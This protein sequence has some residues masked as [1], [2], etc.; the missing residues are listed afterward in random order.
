MPGA[1][2]LRKRKT[3]R[4]ATRSRG[5]E[6]R[7]RPENRKLLQWIEK[8]FE[9]PDQQGEGWW[10]KFESDLRTGR[11]AFRVPKAP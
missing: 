10:G 2:T 7:L 11:L 6:P 9:S 1:S 8:W 5:P 4:A 3:G